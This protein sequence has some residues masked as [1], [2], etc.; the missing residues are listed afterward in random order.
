MI[1]RRAFLGGA[2]AA[3]CLAPRGALARAP[4]TYRIGLLGARTLREDPDAQPLAR[5]FLDGLRSHGWVEGRNITIAR[6][7][8]EEPARYGAAAAELVALRPD[9]IVTPLGEPAALALRD[10]TRTIPIVMLAS[11]DP[12]AAGLV[13]SL[14]HPRGNVTGMSILAAEMGGKRLAILKEAVPGASRVAVLWN[15]TY[16]GKA[17]ELRDAQATAAALK[18][19]LQSFEVTGLGALDHALSSIGSHPPDALIVLADPL[20]VFHRREIIERASKLRVPLVSELRLFA[21]TGALLSYGANLVELYRHAASYVDKILKGVKPADLP[22]E[23]PTIFELV[24][25]LRAARTLGLILPPAL[26]L[27]ADVVI[28]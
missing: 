22:V 1:P 24:I 16:P 3:A 28:E 23:Q 19:L 20:T 4:R 27:R 7:Y 25:N 17:A 8:A 5:A 21:T 18:V 9:V 14:A 15:P 11:V 6:R 26:L 12:V 2:I 13:A 10:A